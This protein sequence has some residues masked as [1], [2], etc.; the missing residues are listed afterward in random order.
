M[1]DIAKLSLLLDDP[2]VRDLLVGLAHAGPARGQIEPGAPRLRAIVLDLAGATSPEQY[3]SWLSDDARNQP[4]TVDQAR[5]VI[6][7]DALGDLAA[8]TGSTPGAVAWQLAGVLPDLV[9]AV[10]PGGRVVDASVLARELAEASLEDDREAGA[11][12]R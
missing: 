8:A 1:A 7:D 11:F 4:M 9:D 2:E 5:A 3:R 10:T 12:G 6:G